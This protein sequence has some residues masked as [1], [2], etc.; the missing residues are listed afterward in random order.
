MQRRVIAMLKAVGLAAVVLGARKIQTVARRHQGIDG[1]SC[2][3]MGL[4]EP[5]RNAISHPI[6]LRLLIPM[7]W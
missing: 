7:R 3:V 4:F 1:A 5:Q 2:R 6:G